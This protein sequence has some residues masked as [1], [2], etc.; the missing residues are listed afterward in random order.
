MGASTDDQYRAKNDITNAVA[1]GFFSGAILARNSGLMGTLGG[2]AAFAAFSGAID[3]YLRKPTAEC[4][5]NC[6]TALTLL[7]I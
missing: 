5:H 3:W 7:M 2:G 4:V 1:G 6:D